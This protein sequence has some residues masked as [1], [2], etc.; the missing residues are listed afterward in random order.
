VDHGDI[1]SDA[2]EVEIQRGIGNSLYGSSAFGGSINVQTNIKSQIEEILFTGSTG[3]YNTYKGSLKYYSGDRYSNFSL[4]ARL[5]SIKSDGYRD[6]SESEQTAFS[7]GLEHSTKKLN[8]QFRVLIGKEIS[9]LQWDGISKEM[10]NDRSRRTGKMDWTV[11]FTDDFLQQIYSLNSRLILS[12]KLIFRN[13]VYYVNGSGFYEV[14]KFDQ[15]YYS[16]NLDVNNEYDDEEEILLTADFTRRKWIQNDYY[17]FVP[18]ITLNPGNLRIDIGAEIRNYQGDHFGE[19]FNVFDP[20]LRSKLPSKYRYYQYD[21]FKNSVST[22]GHLLYSFPFGLHLIGDIQ[23]QKH[24]WEL[25]Q[26]NIGHAVGHNLNATWEFIN[27]RFGLTFDVNNNIALFGNYGM[28]QKE[29]SDAQIIEADDVWSEPKEVASEKIKD[30]ELGINLSFK[31]TYFKIIGYRIDY[32]NEILSDIYDF[33]EGEFDIETADK[34]RH[35]GIELEGGW[36]LSKNLS[37]RANGT[38]GKNI[39]INGDYDGKMLVN[40]PDKLANITL[41]YKSDENFG[42]FVYG[43][44]VGKQYIDKNNTTDIAIDPYILV[45]LNGWFRIGQIKVSAKINNIFDTLYATYGYNY[46][47]GYYWPGATRNFSISLQ[48]SIK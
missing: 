28:A 48:L 8:N 33:A 27:P 44:Y 19:V 17:G 43:K 20:V 23:V 45:N 47:G 37:I 6:Y 2:S 4:T 46:Y 40:V 7:L 18:S 21:G 9:L 1:L 42:V 5:S 26:D 32:F 29:P 22:F 36:M 3:S 39:F 30:I 12:P 34:T 41:D 24:Q 13:V 38:L 31:N 16:Y 10:L 15:D 35:E 11:P 14:E 25:N